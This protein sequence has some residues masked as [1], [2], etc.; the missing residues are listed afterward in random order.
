M[1]T[2]L[3]NYDSFTFN[4][5]QYFQHLGVNPHVVKND[6]FTIEQFQKLSVERLL[7]SPGPGTPEKSG[8]TLHAVR[9][10]CSSTPILGVCLGHEAIGQVF[11]ARLVHARR[12]MHGKVSEIHHDGRG[13]FSGLPTRFKVARYHSLI[14]EG[15]DADHEELEVSAW[16][17]DARGQRDEIMGVRHK[18]YPTEGVQFHPESIL[19]EHGHA[20]LQNFLKFSAAR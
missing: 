15:I 20:I 16:T 5:V 9:N 7:I 12:V 6:E 11:S 1:L 17:V 2:I 18:K 19:A 14:L 4:I 3:D 10:F 8:I 13:V